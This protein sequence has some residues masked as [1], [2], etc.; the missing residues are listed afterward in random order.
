MKIFNKLSRK[1]KRRL[2]ILAIGSA[3]GLAGLTWTTP[4]IVGGVDLFLDVAEELT[5]EEP[6]AVN[7]DQ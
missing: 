7:D 6:E 4:A 2:L 3:A 1:I 5:A